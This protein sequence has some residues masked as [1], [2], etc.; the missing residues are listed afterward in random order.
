MWGKKCG[1]I[2]INLLHR[3]KQ[4]DDQAVACLLIIQGAADPVKDICPG[5]IAVH[6]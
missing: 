6:R 3:K 1:L 4:T 5:R 2:G